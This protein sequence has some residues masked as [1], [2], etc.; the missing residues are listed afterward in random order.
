LAH[1]ERNKVR[2]AHN[3]AQYLPERRQMMRAWAESYLI[4]SGL[5]GWK[6]TVSIDL[7]PL[8]STGPIAI[9]VASIGITL[10][11]SFY[12]VQQEMK[13]ARAKIGVVEKKALDHPEKPQLALRFLAS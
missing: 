11:A 6:M 3:H 2:D 1:V 9:L 4:H 13:N 7:S 10:V 8:L 12:R 5:K